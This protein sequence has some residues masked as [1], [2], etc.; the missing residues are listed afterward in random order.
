MADLERATDIK[1]PRSEP[2]DD[3]AF[4]TFENPLAESVNYHLRN[5]WADLRIARV[6]DGD[7]PTQDVVVSCARCE[8]RY[9]LEDLP[10]RRIPGTEAFEQ[11]R[12]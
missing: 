11:L 3:S 12:S 7:A 10:A 6:G 8:V 9:R 4:A 5:H 2:P 1:T